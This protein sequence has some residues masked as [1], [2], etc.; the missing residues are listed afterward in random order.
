M[1]GCCKLGS[2]PNEVGDH[3]ERSTLDPISRGSSC[4]TMIP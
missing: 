2:R 1:L 4:P 3:E